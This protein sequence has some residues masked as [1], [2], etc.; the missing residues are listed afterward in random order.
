MPAIWSCRGTI[1]C[2]APARRRF[3]IEREVPDLS[4]LPT[5]YQGWQTQ[6]RQKVLSNIQDMSK[7]I[8]GSIEK[9]IA[10]PQR[11]APTVRREAR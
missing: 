8:G 7:Q 4:G 11:G 10:P 9:T 5:L 1:P 2:P 6:N 3:G